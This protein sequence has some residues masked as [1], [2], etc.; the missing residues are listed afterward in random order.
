MDDLQARFE[1]LDHV[2]V[3]DLWPEIERR[4][5][6]ES[7]QTT[8]IAIRRVRR[9]SQAQRRGLTM[10][11]FGRIAAI[12]VITTLTAGL[13]LATQPRQ[14]PPPGL[15]GSAAHSP[16]ADAAIAWDSGSVRLEADAL[17]I[18]AGDKVFT[19]QAPYRVHSD[20]GD[21][22]RRTLEVEWTEDRL[23]QRLYIDFAADERDWWVTGIRTYDGETK[24]DWLVYDDDSSLL[25]ATPRGEAYE[26][27]LQVSGESE[28]DDR[29]IRGEL[30]ITGLRL[31]AFAPGT[32]PGELTGCEN[33]RASVRRGAEPLDEGQPLA[34]SGIEDMTPTEAEAL[35]REMGICFTFRFLYPT[36]EEDRTEG[37]SERWC[38]APPAGE[39]SHLHYLDDSGEV[40]V[41][42]G[43]DEVMATR[44]QPPEGWGC[45]AG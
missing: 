13:F 32:G 3:P 9:T 28:R 16:G 10:L 38:T 30:V 8:P 23:Q 17:E 15:D 1:T 12:G 18:R 42:V 6:A 11:T 21:P 44:D 45:P 24:A 22:T 31:T 36:D 35:L 5:R 34:G 27:D 2:P 29:D 39:I 33:V 41:F 7:D 43:T 40:V 14:P 25:L 19:G 26:G 37:Y 20:P 4:A